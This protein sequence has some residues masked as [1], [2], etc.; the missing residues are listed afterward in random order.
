MLANRAPCCI[1]Q[2]GVL[3]PALPNVVS[4]AGARRSGRTVR[5][6]VLKAELR[7]VVAYFRRIGTPERMTFVSCGML[8]MVAPVVVVSAVS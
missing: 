5:H 2:P 3:S 1:H 6:S 8:D 4:D 7:W